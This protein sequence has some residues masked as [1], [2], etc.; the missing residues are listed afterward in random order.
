[1]AGRKLEPEKIYEQERQLTSQG[2]R[3]LALATGNPDAKDSYQNLGKE[4]LGE[5]T[6]LGIIGIYRPIKARG[7]GF[8]KIRANRQE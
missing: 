2:Y 4:D 1:M 3:V 5:L 8:S 6:F 7:K